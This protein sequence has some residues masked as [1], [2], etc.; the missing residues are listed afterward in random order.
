MT[1]DPNPQIG[2]DVIFTVMFLGFA[3]RIK[4]ME[5]LDRGIQKGRYRKVI[6]RGKRLPSHD[7][8]RRALCQVVIRMKEER[9]T[10]MQD[11][12]GLFDAREPDAWNIPLQD[13][14]QEIKE[15]MRWGLAGHT[16]VLWDTG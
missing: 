7:P 4:S 1:I 9:R 11:V 3:H 10:L 13:V 12:K 16:K 2:S 6:P 8:V 5:E 15:Q 14:I